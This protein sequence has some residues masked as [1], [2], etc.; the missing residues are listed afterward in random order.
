MLKVGLTG[1]IACG[2]SMAAR[3]MAKK[4]AYVVDADQLAREVVE[5]GEPAYREILAWLGDSVLTETGALDRQVL[6]DVVFHDQAALAV[7]NSI[8]HPR[9]LKLF[10]AQSHLL[11]EK[12]PRGILV[13]EVPLLFES[14]LQSAVHLTVVVASSE[15]NQ[16]WRLQSRNGFTRADALLRIASQLPLEQK[17]KA[18]DYVLFN[19]D[20]PLDLQR[21]VDDLWEKLLEIQKSGA[22]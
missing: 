12:D 9:V 17:I 20:T 7:L 15:E 22:E 8:V 3:M 13:W 11:A 14:G 1:G 18:A 4:G 16:L 10:A 6:A 5:P 21:Q 19:N 2:K